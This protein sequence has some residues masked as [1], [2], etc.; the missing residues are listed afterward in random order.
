MSPSNARK[1][2]ETDLVRK[3]SGIFVQGVLDRFIERI[4]SRSNIDGRK[5]RT[6]VNHTGVALAPETLR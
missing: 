2:D 3:L 6:L 5:I 4:R 1:L